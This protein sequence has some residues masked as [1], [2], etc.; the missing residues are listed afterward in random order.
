MSLIGMKAG[1]MSTEREALIYWLN[2]NYQIDQISDELFRLNLSV[3]DN[4][5]QLVFV[6]VWKD[7]FT[8]FSPI[9]KYSPKTVEQVLG[10]ISDNGV[11][12]LTIFDGMLC[13]TNSSLSLHGPT[14]D[15]WISYMGEVGDDYENRLTGGENNL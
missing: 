8:V 10:F 3:G 15:D 4:R 13:I 12:G 9:A 7:N 14:L 11:V 1:G 5:S 2:T 6:S